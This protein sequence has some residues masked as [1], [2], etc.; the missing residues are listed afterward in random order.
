MLC[1]LGHDIN[2]SGLLSSG[3]ATLDDANIENL[4]SI[5]GV[6]NELHKHWGLSINNDNRYL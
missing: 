1:V 6:E 4:K 2:P 3:E 5:H